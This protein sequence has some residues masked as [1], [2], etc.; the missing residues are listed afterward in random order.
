MNLKAKQERWPNEGPIGQQTERG[1]GPHV[2]QPNMD[3]YES[4][5]GLTVEI[6]VPGLTQDQLRLDINGRELRIMGERIPPREAPNNGTYRIVERPHGPFARGLTLPDGLDT[7]QI[8]AVLR[9]GL[10]TISIPRATASPTRRIPV[11]CDD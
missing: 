6:E 5:E 11:R 9:D 3:V 10:L 1:A 7:C 8:N 2:W 4:A